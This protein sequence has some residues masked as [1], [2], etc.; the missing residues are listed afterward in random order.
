L[1]IESKLN[2]GP[3]LQGEVNALSKKMTSTCMT[4]FKK[5]NVEG[6]GVKIQG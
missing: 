6:R 5:E 3:T 1:I 2:N 4:F